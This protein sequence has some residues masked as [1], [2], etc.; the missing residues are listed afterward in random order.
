MQPARSHPRRR[1]RFTRLLVYLFVG[2]TP[3]ACGEGDLR[4]TYRVKIEIEHARAPIDATLVLTSTPLETDSLPPEARHGFGAGLNAADDY[5]GAPNSCL[6]LPSIDSGTNAPRSVTFFETRLRAGEAI[7][8][9]SIF[10]TGEQRMEIIQ[11]HF[12][13]NALGG[14]IIFYEADGERP[15]RLIGDRLDGPT[16][17]RCVEEMQRFHAHILELTAPD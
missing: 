14:D 4:G 10:E 8:P 1:S 9:F 13:A 17:R 6:I 3:M 12:F 2:F 15:G 11:L 5:F 7:V 16:G